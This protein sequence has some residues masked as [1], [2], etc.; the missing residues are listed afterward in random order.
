MGKIDHQEFEAASSKN[1]DRISGELNSL[2]SGHWAGFGERDYKS[3]F[4]HAKEIVELFKTLKP[5][6]KSDRESL[7][8]EYQQICDHVRSRQNEEWRSRQ[9]RSKSEKEVCLRFIRNATYSAKGAR[10]RNEVQNARMAIDEAHSQLRDRSRNMLKDDT[11]ECWEAFRAAKTA[12]HFRIKELQD[13]AYYEAQK[14]V[15]DARNALS[16]Q[17]NPFDALKDYKEAQARAKGLYLSK[18]QF[19]WINGEFDSIWQG[20]QAKIEEYKREKQRKH[21]EWLRRKEEKDRKH[22]EWLNRQYENLQRWESRIDK[23]EDIIRR[24]ENQISDLE[25]QRSNARTDDFADRCAGWINEK[26]NVIA[27]MEATIRDLERK[28]SDVKDK[29]R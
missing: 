24:L 26:R 29:I 22:Q 7:W 6:K 16:Y 12:L 21:E 28:I 15:S 20:I 5:L 27:D 19:R 11:Q 25:D 13:V 1:A 9:A 23:L 2:K 18:D 10:D 3:F 17:S 4:A 8:S 14:A